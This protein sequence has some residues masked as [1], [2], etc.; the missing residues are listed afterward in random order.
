[1]LV[2]VIYL[3]QETAETMRGIYLPKLNIKGSW[4]TTGATQDTFRV[5][6]NLKEGCELQQV[7]VS[8]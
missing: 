5:K 4:K 7:Q 2:N 3:T 8:K 6:S 1:M